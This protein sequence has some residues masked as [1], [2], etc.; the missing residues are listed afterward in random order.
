MAFHSCFWCLR[1]LI[2]YGRPGAWAHPDNQACSELGYKVV[3]E[4]FPRDPDACQYIQLISS[5]EESSELVI[6]IGPEADEASAVAAVP[7]AAIDVLARDPNEESTVE[8]VPRRLFPAV[9]H[10][11]GTRYASGYVAKNRK[12]LSYPY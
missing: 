11:Y 9:P 4:H 7:E 5:D 6:P 1:D 3:I 8:C 12:Y 10:R 2:P